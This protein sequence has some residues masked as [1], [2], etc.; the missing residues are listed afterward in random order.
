MPGTSGEA[1]VARTPSVSAEFVFAFGV[2]N[3]EPCK[4]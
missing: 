3:I 2:S 1:P 4:Y